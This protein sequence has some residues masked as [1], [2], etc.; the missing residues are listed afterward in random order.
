M[1]SVVVVFQAGEDTAADVDDQDSG[2][3][4]EEEDGTGAFGSHFFGR[5][6]GRFRG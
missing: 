1:V 2:D 5:G 6:F 4:E 3:D